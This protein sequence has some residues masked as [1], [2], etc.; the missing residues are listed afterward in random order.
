MAFII[1]FNNQK[2]GVAKTTTAFNLA[3]ALA[4]HGKKVLLVD[5][6]AQANLTLACNI[7]SESL[8]VS[9]SDVLRQEEGQLE[10]AILETR[11]PAIQIVPATI[12]LAEVEVEMVNRMRREWLL[13]DSLSPALL[14]YYDYILI[15][16]PPNLGMMVQNILVASQHVIIPVASQFFSL[17]GLAALLGKI[18]LIK[19]KINPELAV[20]GLLATRYQPR[21]NM[22][23][24]VLEAMQQFPYPT[25]TTLIHEAIKQ[26]E[27]PALGLDIF[28]YAPK[29][30]AAKHYL[31]LAEEILQRLEPTHPLPKNN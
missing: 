18:E 20:L 8:H 10:S 17:Q 25:F 23:R 12:A 27:S 7:E 29:S 15:D 22:S 13:K 19:K 1:S 21:T 5:A 2:G 14:D 26:A 31:A 3:P 9:L 24:Q 28:A 4:E 11:H 6:D 30:E 16:S